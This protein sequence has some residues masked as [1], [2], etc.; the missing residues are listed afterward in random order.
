MGRY[1]DRAKYTNKDESYKDIFIK[2]NVPHIEQYTSPVLFHP[3]EEQLQQLNLVDHVWTLGDRYYKLAATSYG[4][5][6]LWWVIAWFNQLPTEAHVQ[7]GDT[8]QIPF[9][10]ERILKFFKI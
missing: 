10:L 4:D 3:T 8:I 2:K 1:L 7:I 9:P 6:T 5:P